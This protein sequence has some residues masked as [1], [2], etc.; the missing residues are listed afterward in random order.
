[1]SNATI[2]INAVDNTRAAFLGVRRNLSGLQQTLQ[3][4]ESGIVSL[5]RRFIGLGVVTAALSR[6]VREVYTNIENIKGLDP[7]VAASV[8]LLRRDFEALAGDS[9]TVVNRLVATVLGGLGDAGREIGRFIVN[10]FDAA[11][12]AADRAKDEA[13]RL[14]LVLEKI[15]KSPEIEKKTSDVIQARGRITKDLLE[16]QRIG[17]NMSSFTLVGG[18]APTQRENIQTIRDLDMELRALNERKLVL[19]STPLTHVEDAPSR[20]KAI[21]DVL[22]EQ[23]KKYNKIGGILPIIKRQEDERTKAAREAA[24]M[25]ADGFEDAIFS[26]KKLSDVVRQLAMDLVRMAFRSM[27]TAPLG[28]FLGS[29]FG[30]LSL[31]GGARANGGPVSGGKSYL[32]GERGPEIFT[33]SSAGNVISHEKSFSGGGGSTY[34]ID[35]RG[36][37]QTGLARLES[38]IRQTQASIKPIALSSVMESRMRGGAFA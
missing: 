28:N 34:Y 18:K 25:L 36:A 22:D 26:G 2:N 35:A 7:S 30:G 17:V 1:M 33:P 38:L 4:N 37:D 15:L 24:K 8:M 9:G 29:F 23:I 13:E 5:A 6:S 21:N 32:V 11:A 19:E 16:L 27:I 12:R 31:F 14:R 10:P 20:A 3:L